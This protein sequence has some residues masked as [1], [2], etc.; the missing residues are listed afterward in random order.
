MDM[1]AYM[2]KENEKRERK[3]RCKA[4]SR[5]IFLPAALI[6]LPP[7]KPSS[8]YRS[9]AVRVHGE[10]ARI[11]TCGSELLVRNTWQL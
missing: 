1:A 6:Y 10:A 4:E 2:K 11:A 3:T 5:S 7:V 8:R 9:T